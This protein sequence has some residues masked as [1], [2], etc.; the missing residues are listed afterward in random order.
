MNQPDYIFIFNDLTDTGNDMRMIVPSSQRCH[1]LT[2]KIDEENFIWRRQRADF[3]G[4][5]ADL[6]D[7]AISIW[8]A[9]WLAV[10]RNAYRYKILV[11]L[12]VRHPELFGDPS[13]IQHLGEVL[14]WYTGDLWEFDFLQRKENYRLAESQ[15]ICLPENE[16]VEVA[17]W[18]GG[19]DAFAGLYNRMSEFSDIYFTLFGTGSNSYIHCVQHDISKDLRIRFGDR[20]K[21]IQLPFKVQGAKKIQMSHYLRSRGFTNVLLGIACAC[22]ENQNHLYIYENGIG[23]INLPYT[24][25]EVGLDHS[26][27][28]HPKTLKM[29]VDLA[30]HL[31][32][33][34]FT[35]E[36]PFIYKTKA[37][38]VKVLAEKE[39][40]DLIYKTVSCDSKHRQKGLPNQCGFCT[41]C[42]LRRQSIAAAGLQDHT[43]YAITRGKIIKP[44]DGIPFNAMQLQ[45]KK[46]GKILCA[47]EPWPQLAAKYPSLM[48]AFDCLKKTEDEAHIEENLIRLY[49]T[50][51]KEWEL[52]AGIIGKEI[53][54]AS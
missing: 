20:I 45:V 42:L 28:V 29:M 54:K 10:R 15:R 12:P 13:F 6:I 26:R 14:Y 8:A 27:A 23:A 32:E 16:P 48:E 49:Q 4:L 5:A 1:H 40:I 7:L 18:S 44:K 31:L 47:D 24:E 19:L 41:S 46:L 34:P 9:D 33:I 39:D 2:L 35:I 11:E 21:L 37:E 52:V 38:M 51:V 30:S 3:P 36:N 50:Y 43:K 17:L 22:L 25:A 53:L